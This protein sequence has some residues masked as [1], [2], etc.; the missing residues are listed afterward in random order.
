[1]KWL[2]LVLLLFYNLCW[3]QNLQ[4]TSL[5]NNGGKQRFDDVFFL[6]ENTG[7]ALTDFLQQFTKL[8]MVVKPGKRN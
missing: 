6:D 4:S 3:C 8:P 1:M 7:W 2:G 5:F